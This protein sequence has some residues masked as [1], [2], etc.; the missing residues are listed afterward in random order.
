METTNSVFE[1]I[2][3]IEQSIDEWVQENSPAKIKKNVHDHLS[4]AQTDI[5]LKL[6]GFE[7]SYY[8]NPHTYKV[9]HCNGRSGES[10]IGEYIKANL[11]PALEEF[12]S[13]FPLKLSPKATQLIH[14]DIQSEFERKA[15]FM[16]KDKVKQGFDKRIQE[17]QQDY[18]DAILAQYGIEKG[19]DPLEAYNNLMK[20]VGAK[21]NGT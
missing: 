20:L 14:E 18:L 9:D 5:M 6:L 15:R 16:I 7:K 11:Q 4:Q 2:Q 21:D 10:A 13:K 12:V 8:N 17:I 3:T 1:Y 19:K